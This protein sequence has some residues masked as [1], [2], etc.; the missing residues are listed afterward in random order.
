MAG[1]Q[2]DWEFWIRAAGM[3]IENLVTQL[4]QNKSLAIRFKEA[5]CEYIAKD[6]GLNIKPGMVAKII[7]VS[8][9]SSGHGYDFI[10]DFSAFKGQSKRFKSKVKQ[11]TIF[12]AKK[13]DFDDHFELVDSNR[14]VL[15]QKYLSDQPFESYLSWL[16]DQVIDY[17]L[18]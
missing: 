8:E 4:L 11:E 2:S 17:K 16:E 9:H 6:I 18:R 1:K 12:L 3:N 15:Y 14:Q 13:L 10:F 5:F 7:S